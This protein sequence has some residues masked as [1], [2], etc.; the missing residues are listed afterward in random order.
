[1]NTAEI[2]NDEQM[3]QAAVIDIKKNALAVVVNDQD[4]FARAGDIASGLR[5]MKRQVTDWFGPM[6]KKAHEAWKEICARENTTLKPIEEADC[7][8]RG[9]MNRFLAEQEKERQEAERKAR[10]AAENAARKEREKLERQAEKALESG[11]IEKAESLL[12]QAEYVYAEP[13]QVESE[14]KPV[15]TDTA[16]VGMATETVVDVVDLK[17]FVAALVAQKSAMTM[18]D[19]KAAKLKAWV[20]SNGVESFPGLVIKTTK[21]ARIR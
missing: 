3:I 15:K 13:V 20:K 12:E 8:V 18:L 19:V 21:V 5:D 1:M 6:K 10:V 9:K 4:S 16:H 11:K 7:F 17:A 14:I 2:L